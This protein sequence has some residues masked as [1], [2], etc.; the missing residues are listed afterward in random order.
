MYKILVIDDDEVLLSMLSMTLD[1]EGYSVLSTA[2]GPQGI[3]LYKEH[4]PVVVLLDL[5]LP[6]MSGIEVLREIKQFDNKAK[7]IVVTGYRSV[8]SAT[9]AFRYGALD[10]VRK[11]VDI[12]VLLEKIRTALMS[13]ADEQALGE[14]RLR[15]E[16]DI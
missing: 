5:G 12:E 7:V 4:H 16:R 2:D 13:I 10:Y 3:T 11:P 6:S 8:E 1:E 14:R 9:L 15:K